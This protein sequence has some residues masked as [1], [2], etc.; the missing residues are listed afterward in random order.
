MFQKNQKHLQP[1][2]ISDISTMLDA[3]RKRL[4]ESWAP[5]FFEYCFRQI[6]EEI[7]AVLY[8]DEPSRPNVPVNVLV[9]LEI[10]KSPLCHNRVGAM[11][12]CTTPFS[13]ICKCAMPWAMRA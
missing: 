4:Q 7:F 9:G 1:S 8:A 3:Q 5:V 2:L 6:G 12:S 13:L 11:P 10:L